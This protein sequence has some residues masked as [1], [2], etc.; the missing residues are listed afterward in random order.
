MLEARRLMIDQ[1]RTNA[2]LLEVCRV[3]KFHDLNLKRA[4]TFLEYVKSGQGANPVTD[5]LQETAKPNEASTLALQ[6]PPEASPVGPQ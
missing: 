2:G 6:A 3:F 1:P 4:N 5:F